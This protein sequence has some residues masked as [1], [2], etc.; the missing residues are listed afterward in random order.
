MPSLKTGGMTDRHWRAV[1]G[2]WVAYFT[3]AE[4]AALKS[5]SHKA[6]FSYFM[7]T[8]LGVRRHPLHHRAGQAAL[9]TGIA[10]LTLHI[11]ERRD[12]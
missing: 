1:W 9:V 4:Y 7:R 3:V 12:R 11:Y 10:W 8:T 5:G 6:P 2:F